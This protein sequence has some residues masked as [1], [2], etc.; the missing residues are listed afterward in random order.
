[1]TIASRS[2]PP[3]YASAKMGRWRFRRGRAS[4][5]KLRAEIILP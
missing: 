1:M 3:P 4:V 2:A 5:T